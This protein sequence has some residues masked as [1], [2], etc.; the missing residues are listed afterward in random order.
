MAA[1]AQSSQ[2]QGDVPFRDTLVRGPG[3]GEG[4]GSFG[5]LADGGLESKLRIA[6][7]STY[8]YTVLTI[9]QNLIINVSASSQG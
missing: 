6:V 5:R 4:N 8:T 2:V 1:L 7:L 9:L 3:R